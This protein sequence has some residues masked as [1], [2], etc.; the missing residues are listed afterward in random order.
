[1]VERA[2]A[3]VRS[4]DVGLERLVVAITLKIRRFLVSQW[5]T[6]CCYIRRRRDV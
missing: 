1:M 6:D 2:L 5:C 4:K 3:S